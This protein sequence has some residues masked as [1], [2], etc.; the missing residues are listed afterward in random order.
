M[1]SGVRLLLELQDGERHCGVDHR[2]DG[3]VQ[4]L[5]LWVATHVSLRA[6]ARFGT[7]WGLDTLPVI[8]TRPPG[9]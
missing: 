6:L 3:G 5:L 8:N 9:L 4:Q 1:V 7:W 2:G